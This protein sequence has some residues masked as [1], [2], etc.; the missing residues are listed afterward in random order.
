[1]RREFAQELMDLAGM[2]DVKSI[3]I[4]W[5]DIDEYLD[6][7]LEDEGFTVTVKKNKLE[8]RK[9]FRGADCIEPIPAGQ[10]EDDPDLTLEK[11]NA[12]RILDQME[13]K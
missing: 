4:T 9:D 2:L 7:F 11:Y 3:G 5:H 8:Y 1:M 13:I 6:D 10:L 12:Q